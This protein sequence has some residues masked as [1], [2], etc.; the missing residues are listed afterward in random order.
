[1]KA[2]GSISPHAGSHDAFTVS[3]ADG[4]MAAVYKNL[5]EQDGITRRG[6][7]H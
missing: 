4:G 3:Y 6:P 1:M 5:R 7:D 2:A